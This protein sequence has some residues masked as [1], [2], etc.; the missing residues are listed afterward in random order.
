MNTPAN[1]Y[2][3]SSDEWLRAEDDG[4]IT[5]GITDYAQHELGEIVYVEL[6]E[7]GATIADGAPFGV[8]ES[9]KAVGELHSPVSGVIVA[10]NQTTADN[11]SIVNESPYEDGWL[12]TIK[13]DVEV[14]WS[15]LLTPEAYSAL[16]G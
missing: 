16:H 2:Y 1:L 14:D 13:P 15:S 12:V 11:S 10:T 6:P 5:I 9:V 4:N 8:V 7:I 3:T